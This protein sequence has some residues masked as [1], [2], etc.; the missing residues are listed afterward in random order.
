MKYLS[1]IYLS[2]RICKVQVDAFTPSILHN[3]AQLMKII[4][5]LCM[6]ALPTQMYGL[7]VLLSVIGNCPVCFKS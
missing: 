4:Y 6:E 7:H 5:L 3:D 1:V 2:Q